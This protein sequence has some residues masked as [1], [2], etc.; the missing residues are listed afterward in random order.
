MSSLPDSHSWFLERHE[1]RLEL[2]PKKLY[3]FGVNSEIVRYERILK[4][5]LP[6]KQSA[7]L[8]GARKTGKSTL[9]KKSF[10]QSLWFDFLDTDLFFQL[11]KRPALFRE[12]I[13]AEENISYLKY[14]IIVDEV[15]KIPQVLDEI[16]WLIENKGFQFVLCGSSARKL[17]RNHANLLGG[18][19][20]RYE[21]FPLTSVEIGNVDLLRAANHG[22]IPSHYLE[23]RY[24]KSLESYVKDYLKEEIMAEGA[25][26]NLPAFARFLDA[27]GYSQGE[28]TNFSNIASDAG[29][30]SKTVREYYQILVDTLLGTFISPFAKKQSRQVISKASKFYLFDVGIAGFLSK[31]I[32]S[33]ERGIL[34]GKAFEHFI[35]MELLAYRSYAEKDFEIQFWRTKT[36]Q[37]VDFILGDGVVALEVKGSNR[38]N[39]S[40]IRSLSAFQEEFR[41]RK[42][43]VVCNEPK[44]RKA[45]NIEVLPWKLFLAYLWEGKVL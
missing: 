5:R 16:H 12:Q 18:R 13:L 26:R 23:N 9:L 35:L 8:W 30:D 24:T 4:L 11:T 2:T 42:A 6:P 43:L 3:Y 44:P 31:R 37:E 40:D 15:Q 10:P 33:E 45:D 22:L 7:F 38:I 20:W 28:I 36:G 34:F 14:P 17:K 32:I 27:L 41:P 1:I 25:V 21:L 19:A 29:V 39:G